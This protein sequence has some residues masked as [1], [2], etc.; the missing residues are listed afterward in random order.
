MKNVF[1]VDAYS[2]KHI[3]VYEKGRL[4]T[5][6]KESFVIYVAITI[7]VNKNYYQQQQH[8]DDE[9]EGSRND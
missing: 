6:L 2:Y 4:F 8:Q 9:E 5:V 7:R 1:I 3:H